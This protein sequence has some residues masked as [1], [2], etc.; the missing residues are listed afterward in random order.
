MQKYKII[1]SQHTRY[2]TITLDHLNFDMFNADMITF[3]CEILVRVYV[4]TTY[5]LLW[6]GP[7]GLTIC[8]R[9]LVCLPSWLRM[10]NVRWVRSMLWSEFSCKWNSSFFE[11]V[12]PNRLPFYLGNPLHYTN[13]LFSH[14]C[15]LHN[16]VLHKT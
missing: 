2:Y 4:R 16:T 6:G 8:R 9:G 12:L 5:H 14:Y 3:S 10:M 11:V 15:L 7:S 13:S 1:L